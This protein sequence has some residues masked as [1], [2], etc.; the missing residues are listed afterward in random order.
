MP[1]LMRSSLPTSSTTD[2]APCRSPEPSPSND[3]VRCSGARFPTSPS[4]S[5][6]SSPLATGCAAVGWP[7]APTPA[8]CG[9]IGCAPSHWQPHRLRGDPDRPSCGRS[10]RRMLVPTGPVAPVAAARPHLEPVRQQVSRLR[11]GIPSTSVRTEVTR[12][13]A[14]GEWE[15]G[16]W[17]G[18]A[19]GAVPLEH[20]AG[21]SRAEQ[22]RRPAHVHQGHLGDAR[23][24]VAAVPVAQPSWRGGIRLISASPWLLNGGAKLLWARN[25]GSALM[26]RR[27]HRGAGVGG[28][29]FLAGDVDRGARRSG[30]QS[31]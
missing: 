8:S 17:A 18:S 25:A 26:E 5:A 27:R 11:S 2:P 15:H 6:T 1:P 3:R 23:A 12:L 4:T 21:M 16:R 7:A 31:D 10:D 24:P 9:S 13:T 14:R 22:A 28:G 30:R 29:R 19:A 20:R